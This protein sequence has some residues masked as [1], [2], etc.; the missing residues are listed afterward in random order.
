MTQGR[1]QPPVRSSGTTGYNRPTPNRYPLP[2]EA[3]RAIEQAR[4][5]TCNAALT[6][7]RY[8]SYP[9][10]EWK[11][12]GTARQEKWTDICDKM[13]LAYKSSQMADLLLAIHQRRQR[14][15]DSLRILKCVHERVTAQVSWRLIIGLGLPSPLDT[16]MAL[17]KTYGIPYVPGSHVKGLVH[18]WG[19]D[20]AGGAL[21]VPPMG[22]DSY[23]HCKDARIATPLELL[24]AYLSAKNQDEANR[25]FERLRKHEFLPEDASMRTMTTDEAL[26]ASNRD[27]FSRVFGS[28]D[29]GGDVIFLDA[30]PASLAIGKESI[31]EL[32]VMNPHYGDYY[33]ESQPPAD[34]LD[35]TPVNFLTLRK[36]TTFHFDLIVLP[37]GSTNANGAAQT[38]KWCVDRLSEA[39]EQRGVGGKTRADY[40]RMTLVN[41]AT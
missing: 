8:V 40:G 4:E 23:Q 6:L 5:P 21:G 28:T 34:Y 15:L 38:I 35:P 30:F 37:R 14:A 12:E 17:H 33:T 24:D 29:R 31:L 41:T 16:G 11:M 27:L 1:G 7:T 26:Q 19:L 3:A 18:S 32:D 10:V 22:Q 13:S 25:A 39:L 20:Q 36:G 2:R 9:T